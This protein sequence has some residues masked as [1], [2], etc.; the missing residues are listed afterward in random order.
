MKKF[1]ASFIFLIFSGASL[2]ALNPE[3]SADIN[4]TVPT[5]FDLN[6]DVEGRTF[7]MKTG[8]GAAADFQIFF[9]PIIGAFIETEFY[10]PS[11]RLMITDDERSSQNSAD[12]DSWWGFSTLIGPSFRL[13]NNRIISMELSPGFALRTQ[14]QAHSD[15]A[16]AAV[17]MGTGLNYG[18]RFKIGKSMYIRLG[19]ELDLYF[20]RWLTE[21]YESETYESEDKAF[22]LNA[23]ESIGIGFKF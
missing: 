3:L 2:F 5:I 23:T 6:S 22:L 19:Q 9:N 21:E 15:Y 17:F 11:Y 16:S 18:L 10:F 1:L 14:E 7:D 8:F 4:F 12:F 20:H 13:M